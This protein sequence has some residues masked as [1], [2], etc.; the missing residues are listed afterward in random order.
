MPSLTTLSYYFVLILRV[1]ATADLD[2]DGRLVERGIY[3]DYVIV[4]IEKSLG[5]A[6][7]D[8]CNKEQVFQCTTAYVMNSFVVFIYS[9]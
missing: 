1:T 4:S 7:L 6:A 9:Q 8:G 5:I 2:D 3:T